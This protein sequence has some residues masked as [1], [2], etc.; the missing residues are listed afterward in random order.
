MP[1]KVDAAKLAAASSG[2][3]PMRLPVEYKHANGDAE[4]SILELQGELIADS[5]ASLKLGQL[6]YQKGVPTLLIGTHLLEGKVVKL[7]KPMAIMRKKAKEVS[8]DDTDTTSTA[9][10]VVGIA[11]KKLVFNSRPKPVVDHLSS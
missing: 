10:T 11:R 1:D 5:K 4:W 7:P 6:Q 8:A 3:P 2:I 9:Y